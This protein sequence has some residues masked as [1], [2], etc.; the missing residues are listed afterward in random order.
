[1]RDLASSSRGSRTRAQS[2]AKK[3]NHGKATGRCPNTD[4]VTQLEEKGG[5]KGLDLVR[6]LFAS[7]P[8]KLAAWA[9]LLDE[10]AHL[11][12]GSRAPAIGREAA[13]IEL[14]GLLSTVGGF[15]RNYL[16]IWSVPRATW[17]ETDLAAAT[18]VAREG[19]IAT[20][21]AIVFRTGRW[22]LVQDVR[23]YFDPGA[24]PAIGAAH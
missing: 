4:L 6:T 10:H 18:S 8:T 19:L 12:L 24:L 7:D 22:H 2:P 11:R 21:C 17:V 5:V 23:F 20:P 15:G 16:E 3:R 9:E 1:L 14:A 13:L